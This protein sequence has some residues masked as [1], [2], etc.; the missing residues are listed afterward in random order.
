MGGYS[1]YSITTGSNNTAMGDSAME[2]SVTTSNNTAVGYEGAH[3]SHRRARISTSASA[4]KPA[5]TKRRAATN[6]LHRARRRRRHREQLDV[7]YGDRRGRESGRKQRDDSRRHGN[8]CRERGHQYA[9]AR[10]PTR[11]RRPWSGDLSASYHVCFSTNDSLVFRGKYFDSNASLARRATSK[12]T[13]SAPTRS[14]AENTAGVAAL[15][16]NVIVTGTLTKGGGSFKIDDPIDP[17]G[18]Y[19]S[20][21]F[22]ESPDMMNIY[23]GIVTLDAHGAAVVTMP[24]WFSALNRDFRYTL[25]AIGSPAPKIYVAEKMD[26]NRFKIAGGKRGQEISWMVTGIRQDAWANAHR[27]PNEEPKPAEEQ[28]KYLHP[29]LFRS[30]SRPID[31]CEIPAAK[32]C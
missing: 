7:R 10:C 4:I 29:E 13:A 20:H 24:E 31:Q 19:L 11:N 2:D 25:T 5:S 26:G 30:R 1:L 14:T 17:S 22:V 3:S 8:V 6:T 27:I 28:G 32:R 16:G 21:S 9:S 18:K 12:C 15:E 23:N